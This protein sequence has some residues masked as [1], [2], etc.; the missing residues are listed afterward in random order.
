MSRV[1]AKA[2][3]RKLV[4][5]DVYLFKFVDVPY[6]EVRRQL[7]QDPESLIQ[8]AADHAVSAVGEHTAR[9]EA[10]LG[11]LAVAADVDVEFDEFH[12]VEKPLPICWRT[13]RWKASRHPGWFPLMEGTIEVIPRSDERTQVSFQ[14]R[15]RPPLSVLGAA[16][17]AALLHRVAEE[18]LRNLF[19]TVVAHLEEAHG[20]ETGEDGADQGA[21][22]SNASSSSP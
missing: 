12:D 21:D 11:D 16:A 7:S 1:A 9:L 20:R 17:D 15:Y 2:I 3:G 19:R 13:F 8:P 14:G 10:H 5:K 22:S 4:S 18:S 6:D